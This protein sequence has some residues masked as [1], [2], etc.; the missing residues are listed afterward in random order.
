MPNSLHSSKTSFAEAVSDKDVLAEISAVTVGDAD[1]V[2]TTFV[3]PIEAALPR[4]LADAKHSSGSL[5]SRLSALDVIPEG[6]DFGIVLISGQEFIDLAQAWRSLTRVPKVAVLLDL[7]GV[8][9]STLF[10]I[11]YKQAGIPT[12]SWTAVAA[13]LG[14]RARAKQRL[15]DSAP[16]LAADLP[17]R[18]ERVPANLAFGPEDDA[19]IDLEG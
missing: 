13:G 7:P 16:Y 15:T 3:V 10:T 12:T 6:Q 11:G 4:E 17:Q 5:Y 2:G 14:E 18:K 1:A 19:P 8:R 9:Y